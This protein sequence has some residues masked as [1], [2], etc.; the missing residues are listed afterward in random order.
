MQKSEITNGQSEARD[1]ALSSPLFQLV[2]KTWRDFDE[3][4]TAP[5]SLKEEDIARYV[6][7]CIENI[8]GDEEDPAESSRGL[9][10]SIVTLLRDNRCPTEVIESL[11]NIIC[12]YVLVCLDSAFMYSYRQDIYTLCSVA[13]NSIKKNYKQEVSE[14]KEKIKQGLLQ[15]RL[16]SELGEWCA[17]HLLN[18]VFL[19]DEEA[20]WNVENTSEVVS[21]SDYT[22]DSHTFEMTPDVWVDRY[23]SKITSKFKE[24]AYLIEKIEKLRKLY[25]ETL[26]KPKF[27]RTGFLRDNIF[28][29]KSPW[30]HD[31]NMFPAEAIRDMFND[32]LFR[33]K[34][35]SDAK[36][37]E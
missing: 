26:K 16:T 3:E 14:R 35:V 37:K 23:E 29:P 15:S 11:S 36:K 21:V 12:A 5:I 17:E 27:N 32:T 25:I 2:D 20:E 24:R 34:T 28:W 33:D 22:G 8:K 9:R 30:L 6:L 4:F 10:R 19:T 31:P 7:W 18:D 1:K 13:E